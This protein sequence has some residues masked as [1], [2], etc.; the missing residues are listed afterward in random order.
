[1]GQ[2]FKNKRERQRNGAPK[3]VGKTF[4]LSPD[5]VDRIEK[6]VSRYDYRSASEVVEAAL[7]FAFNANGEDDDDGPKDG[8]NAACRHVASSGLAPP[9]DA[10]W[11]PHCRS[12]ARCGCSVDSD[13]SART[14]WTF[15]SRWYEEFITGSF[16]EFP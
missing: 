11:R 9:V 14:L 12:V 7:R 3:K 16:P 5:L 6:T 10:L 8:S 13:S 2:V 4:T 1:M 15:M